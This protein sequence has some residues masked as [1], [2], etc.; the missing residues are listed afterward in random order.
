[1]RLLHSAPL[2]ILVLALAAGDMHMGNA[3]FFAPAWADDGDSGDDGDDG[4]D[5]SSSVGR[6][7]GS[8]GAARS[9]GTEGL[10]LREIRSRLRGF[11]RAEPRRAP[12]QRDVPRPLAAEREIVTRG[13]SPEDA[14]TLVALGFGLLEEVDLTSLGTTARRFSLPDDVTPDAARAAIQALPTGEV[15]DLNHYYRTGEAP[16]AP[17]ATPPCEGMHCAALAQVNWPPQAGPAGCGPSLALGMID[18]GLNPDHAAL[19]DAAI[20][21]MRVAP[22]DFEASDAIHGTA[23][24]ALLVGDPA[25]RAPGLLPG[26]PLVAVDAFHKQSGDERADA[27][28]LLRALDH[29]SAR[30]VE[31]INLSLAGP[32]NALL[33]TTLAQLSGERG[34]V[35]VAA[36]GNGGPNAPPAYPAAYDSVIAVTAVD[37]NA[38]AYRRAGRGPHLD[39]AAPGVEVWTAA[40]IE[41][42]RWKTGTSFAAPFVTA[43]AAL[44]RQAHPGM[45][46]PEIALALAAQARDLGPAGPDPVYG[47]GLLDLG[48]R[49]PGD[50]A[51]L[52]AAGEFPR[53]S[54]A[55]GE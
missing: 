54:G 2:L 36:A 55:L 53:S 30:G 8:R 48:G 20:D 10:S 28:T 41:G 1:M 37:R 44:W 29:L 39:L 46:P 7:G 23:V 52:P 19:R 38:T 31:V 15:A 17:A 35:I 47:N 27:F 9:G 25:S 50:M 51:P 43:A 5:S 42:A 45:T 11:L 6:S 18:T 4:D 33:E 26:L 32:P 34:I 22:E 13:L 12:R 16:G 14:A 21:V 3:P 40:S 49:C 24:A